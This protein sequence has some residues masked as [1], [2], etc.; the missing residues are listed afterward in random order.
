[1]IVI[2]TGIAHTAGTMKTTSHISV[3]AIDD[4]DDIDDDCFVVAGAKR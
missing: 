4:D 1:L 3:A 2:C